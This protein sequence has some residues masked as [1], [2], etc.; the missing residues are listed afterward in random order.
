MKQILLGG[1][2]LAGRTLDLRNGSPA[3][4]QIVMARKSAGLS[5][6]LA[7]ETPLPLQAVTILLVNDR[8]RIE[9]R[10]HDDQYG[11]FRMDHIAPGKYRLFA[12]EQFDSDTW[13]P[14]SGRRPGS[15]IAA[16]GTARR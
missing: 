14:E 2:A 12:L 1:E 15:E 5:G 16:G 6:K 9:E 8:G 3:G 13:N 10:V 11:Q 4:M 7:G